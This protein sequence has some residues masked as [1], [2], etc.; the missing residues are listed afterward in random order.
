MPIWFPGHVAPA[1]A[2]T[3]SFFKDC[4]IL[5]DANAWL[6]IYRLPEASSQNLMEVLKE[7]GETTR[8][9]TPHQVTEEFVRNHASVVLDAGS[10]V[11]EFLRGLNDWKSKLLNEKFFTQNKR[12]VQTVDAKT[13]IDSAFTN[14]KEK[15]NEEK[16]KLASHSTQDAYLSVILG[17]MDAL[18]EESFD[19]KR[20]QVLSEEGEHRF[21]SKIPP[22]FEDIKKDVPRRYS[23]YF[24]WIE[25]IEAAKKHNFDL[26]FVT[27]DMKPDW[28]ELGTKVARTE[29][30]SEFARRTKKRIWIMPL[31]DFLVRGTDLGLA[32]QVKPSTIKDVVELPKV[33]TQV[34]PRV[35]PDG[36]TIL[37]PGRE[38]LQFLYGSLPNEVLTLPCFYMQ[39][40]DGK[41]RL[42]D[43]DETTQ[44]FPERVSA[45]E[46]RNIDAISKGIIIGN[47]I[48]TCRSE[49]WHKYNGELVWIGNQRYR[50][51]IIYEH[52][53]HSKF[54]PTVLFSDS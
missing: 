13:I 11:D 4:K 3:A 39:E 6:D 23:D 47:L 43:A 9:Y 25:A 18:R 52:Y 53:L 8:L 49:H 29:L 32:S 50:T 26:L 21:K 16:D 27:S 42:I 54:I 1:E 36:R 15:V 31:D 34:V 51:V 38:L 20:I 7:L 48:G 37:S 35:L 28:Y 2:E 33:E 22:G 24:I 46:Q 41:I 10:R 40:I 14:I 17:L 30:Y 44:F 45:S 5:L 12:F 19:A